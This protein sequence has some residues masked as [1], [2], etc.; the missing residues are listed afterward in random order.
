MLILGLGCE[1]NQMK[2]ML[3]AVGKI[4][5]GR[6]EYFNAQ[7]VGDEVEEGIARIRKLADYARQGEARADAAPRN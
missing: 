3:E 5:P 6:V 7:E 1:N 4:A 2:L